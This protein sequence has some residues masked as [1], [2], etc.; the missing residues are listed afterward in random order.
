MPVTRLHEPQQFEHWPRQHV[1]SL[2]QVER[3][4]LV[5]ESHVSQCASQPTQTSPWQYSQG[6]LQARH[7]FVVA[8]QISHLPAQFD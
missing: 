5:C 6:P 7:C 4:C 3:H 2:A 8:S 1:R